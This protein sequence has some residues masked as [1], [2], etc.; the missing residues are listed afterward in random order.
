MINDNKY[1]DY[2]LKMYFFDAGKADAILIEKNNKYIMID[3][4]LYTLKDDILDY[5]KKNNIEELEYLIITHFD[6]DHVGSAS[7]I[8]NDIRVNNIIVTNTKKDSIYY[9]NYIEAIE[10]KNIVPTVVEDS[11]NINLEDLKIEVI[12]SKK[13]YEEDESNNSSLIVSLRYNNNSFLF[14]G[15]S[16]KERIDDFINSNNKKYDFIKIPYHGKSIDNLDKLL[17]NIDSSYGVITCS[18]KEGCSN[19]TLKV[20][21]KYDIKYYLTRNGDIYVY[22]NG[23]EIKIEQ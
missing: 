11:M 14:M 5:F 21:D 15:D 2:D 4:G 23:K 7:Y 17:D 1:K 13:V 22:S 10:S 19:K 3:T 12:G 16:K 8:I 18:N 20:L 6:K 9:D